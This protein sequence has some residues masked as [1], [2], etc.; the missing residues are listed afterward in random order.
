[1]KKN[2]VFL[3]AF[4]FSIVSYSQVQKKAV[5]ITV[6]CLGN[7][8]MC[9]QRIEAAA[10]A[11]HGVVYA[12]WSAGEEKL[13]IRYHE[14]VTTLEEIL[15]T[16]AYV[17]HDNSMYPAPDS[18]YNLLVGTCCEYERRLSYA[19]IHEYKNMLD[20]NLYPNP[21]VQEIYFSF[22]NE[23]D[24]QDAVISVYSLD[25]S[26]VYQ[27]PAGSVLEKVSLNYV[28]TGKYIVAVSNKTGILYR[29]TIVKSNLK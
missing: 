25:G 3:F 9:D 5:Q 11:I 2:I 27:K 10:L 18:S 19:S 14:D 6:D 7:C 13:T 4:L 12:D 8:Y 16:V 20:V 1:M 15:H 26:L 17:G 22:K 21:F 28:S 29:S 23:S 24:I